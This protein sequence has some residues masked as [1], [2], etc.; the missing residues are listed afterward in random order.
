MSNSNDPYKTGLIKKN[1]FSDW[2]G[3]LGHSYAY[4]VNPS[5]DYSK[6]NGAK[7]C[8]D[9]KTG[10]FNPALCKDKDKWSMN[11]IW[12]WGKT[13]TGYTASFAVEIPG[14]IHTDCNRITGNKY[15]IYTGSKCE[16][17]NGD[18]QDK[19]NYINNTTSKIGYVPGTLYSA[20]RIPLSSFKIATSFYDDLNPKCK[21]FVN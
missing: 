11:N 17:S 1:N 18:L 5:D 2:I 12:A 14:A 10:F 8:T 21:R 15:G 13:I 16:D 4:C 6:L 7:S 19:Y 3:G 20:G 9:P